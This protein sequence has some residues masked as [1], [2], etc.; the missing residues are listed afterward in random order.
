MALITRTSRGI[1]IQ[2]TGARGIRE[3]LLAGPAS[4]SNRFTVRKIFLE[5]DG[6]TARNSFDRTT[7]YFVHKGRISMSHGSGELDLL[8]PGDSVTVNPDELHHLHNIDKMKAVVIKV[9]S[10]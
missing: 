9:A 4:G 8:S 7:V 1:R 6:C 10:Q 2:Q 5:A 3:A